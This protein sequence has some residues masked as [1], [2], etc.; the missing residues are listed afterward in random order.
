MTPMPEITGVIDA[1]VEENF[2][3]V[4]GDTFDITFAYPVGYHHFTLTL[5]VRLFGIDAYERRDPL[6]PEATQ[7]TDDWVS[8]GYFGFD[9]GRPFRVQLVPRNERMDNPKDR[10][11]RYLAR[12]WRKSDGA[13]LN[14]ALVDAGLAVY[15]EYR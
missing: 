7:F 14:D 8:E 9:G 3:P 2:D 11:D 12:I 5:R 1:D 4:D 13:C 6:G 10:L 15:K